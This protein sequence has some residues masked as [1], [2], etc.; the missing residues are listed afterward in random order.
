MTSDG[1][2]GGQ[3]IN[4]WVWVG[5]GLGL[6][7]AVGLVIGLVLS[8]GDDETADTTTTT[9]DTT[10]T[11]AAETTTTAAETT[12][13]EASTTTAPPPQAVTVDPTPVRAV[14]EPYNEG[15]A[16]LFPAGSVEANWYQWDGFYV[17]LYRG[18]D[19]EAATPICP[20]NSI[21]TADGF[22]NVTNSPYNGTA[23]EICVGTPKIAEPPAGAYACGPLLYYLTEIPVTEVGNL[24]GTLEVSDGSGP[25]G[26]TS[27]VASDAANTPEFQPDQASY[28]LPTSEFDDVEIVTCGS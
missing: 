28:Q 21:Q 27:A 13:T 26:Q 2:G 10:T 22:L 19:A 8:G 12:T 4:L 6:V 1:D 24:F 7:V 16:A 20:G 15:G 9:A 25:V 3:G 23:D 11:T 17:V 14:L 18:W 5:V